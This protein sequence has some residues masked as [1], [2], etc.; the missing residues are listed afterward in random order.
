MVKNSF[1]NILSPPRVE[2]HIRIDNDAVA[3]VLIFVKQ[4]V[5]LVLFIS[6]RNS[7]K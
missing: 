5:L 6:T 2:W 1:V 7:K 4:G 3:K